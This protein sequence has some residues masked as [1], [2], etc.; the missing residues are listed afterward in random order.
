MKCDMNPTRVFSAFGLILTSALS[1]HSRGT[2]GDAPFS[3]DAETHNIVTVAGR[4]AEIGDGGPAT[5]AQLNL[6]GSVAF[7]FSGN[8]YIT[9]GAGH[10]VRKVDA[11]GIITTFAGTGGSGF[12]GDYIPATEAQLNA[13]R[14]VTVDPSGNN[15]YIVENGGHRIRKINLATGIITTVAGT[16]LAGSTGDG[17]S[18]T[19]AQLN[20]P[21]FAVFD[22][23]GNLYISEV[24]GQ[25][26]RKV[27][28]GSDGVIDGTSDEIITTIAGTGVAGFMGD[29]FP[30]TAAQFRNPNAVSN[31]S[32]GNL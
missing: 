5:S 26:I 29:G 28:P 7:D 30:A 17:G 4:T 22:S 10:R 8:R 9:E 18:A 19:A 2:A 31:D 20:A 14:G 12:N 27:V 13:P 23:S 1:F 32:A 16:G 25:R 21:G 11:A 6:P 24:N 3:L 15:L